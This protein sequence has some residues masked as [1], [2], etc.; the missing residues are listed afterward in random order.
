MLNAGRFD[1]KCRAKEHKNALQW[2]KS[3][4]CELWGNRVQKGK[5]A[6][7]KWDFGG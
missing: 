3:N 6:A 7:R 2:Y 5:I 1:A 4:P